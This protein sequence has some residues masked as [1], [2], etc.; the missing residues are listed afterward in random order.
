MRSVSA[1]LYWNRNGGQTSTLSNAGSQS[2]CATARTRLCP[3]TARHASNG[4]A[5]EASA[6]C[7]A[8]CATTPDC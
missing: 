2:F 6:C 5:D 8:C 7:T 4:H 1:E 3:T